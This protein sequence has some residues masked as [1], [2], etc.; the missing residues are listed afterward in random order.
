MERELALCIILSML[1]VLVMTHYYGEMML[2]VEL[3][4]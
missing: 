1:A 4:G 2:A 3:M